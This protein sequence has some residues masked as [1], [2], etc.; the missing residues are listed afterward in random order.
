M[1][2]PNE[3]YGYLT[4]IRD[5]GSRTKNGSRIMECKC[6]CGQIVYRSTDSINNSIR[7]NC[8]ISCGCESPKYDIGNTFAHDVKRKELSRKS[9]G[10][11][12]GTTMQGINRKNINKNNKSGYRG[13]CFKTREQKWQ[14]DI[15]LRGESLERKMFDNLEEAIQWRK[16]LEQKYF[17]PIKEK[18]RE[19]QN[20]G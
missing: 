8:V 19:E 13:V 7:K 16:Y 1:M 9:L 17:E 6:V 15:V 18:F 10:Q 12:D 20:N 14:A 2:Q 5:S 4:I 11:I 3:K